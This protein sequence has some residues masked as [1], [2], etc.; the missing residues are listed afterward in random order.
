MGRRLRMT[1]ELGDWLAELG[2]SEPATAAEVGAALVAVMDSADPAG[3]AVLGYP[4][5]ATLRDPRESADLAYQGLLEEL[6]QLRRRVADAASERRKAEFRLDAER[7]AGADASRLA[8]LEQGLAAAR[9]H[10]VLLT[11]Q[12]QRIQ[13]DV[14]AFRTDKETAKAMYAAAEGQLRAADA[15]RAVGGEPGAGL[16]QLREAV[17]VAERKLQALLSGARVEVI[18]QRVAQAGTEFPAPAEHHRSPQPPS[19]AEP[20]PGLLELR[21]DSLGSDIRILLA[22][23]PADT[24]TLLAVLEGPEAVSEHGAEAIKLASDLLTEIREDG[25]PSDVDEV[26]LADTD[27]FLARFFPADDGSIARRA[28]VIAGTVQLA[29]LRTDKQL[30]IEQLA[31]RSGMDADRIAAIERE[32]LRT[33]LVH[34]AVAL[35]R[36]L[37]ARLELPAGGRTALG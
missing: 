9:R 17:R 23:E 29:K 2:E 24:V 28:S 20:A 12:S 11:Q 32:G 31:A 15:M 36:A 4:T 21:A 8:E 3:L 1:A 30:T 7:A 27:A 18:R 16:D 26:A 22:V 37:G 35:G 33:A 19:A 10:E 5:A 34:E 25:W 14:D 6:Q 13:D